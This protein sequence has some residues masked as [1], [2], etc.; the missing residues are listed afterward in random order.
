MPKDMN[1]IFNEFNL[2]VKKMKN[3]K[4]LYKNIFIKY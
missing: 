4:I 3:E 1:K 2:K